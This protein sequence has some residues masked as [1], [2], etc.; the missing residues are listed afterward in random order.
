MSEN[1]LERRRQGDQRKQDVKG[2]KQVEKMRQKVRKDA[3][4]GRIR[5][6][7][8]EREEGKVKVKRQI[9]SEEERE[10]EMQRA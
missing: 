9:F 10:K 3:K 8:C 5:R 2:E 6:E 4:I 1:R 7:E